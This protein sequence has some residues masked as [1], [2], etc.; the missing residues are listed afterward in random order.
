M[1]L[2]CR[3]CS[4]NTS[5]STERIQ[6]Q[7]PV[8][9]HHRTP[10]RVS[11][12]R[13]IS[14]G[15]RRETCT[16]WGEVV[17]HAEAVGCIIMLEYVWVGSNFVKT[18]RKCNILAVSLRLLNIL[19]SLSPFFVC[20]RLYCCCSSE[21]VKLLADEKV[22]ISPDHRSP[23]VKRRFTKWITSCSVSA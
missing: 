12:I 18:Y 20:L 22:D 7:Y 21:Q 16:H 8:S 5:K 6:H 19:A 10:L 11:I 9:R 23:I 13:G 1:S 3:A 14:L 4:R 15:N 17:F 2:H